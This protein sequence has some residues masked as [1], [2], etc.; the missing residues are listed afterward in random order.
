MKVRA[1]ARAAARR[2]PLE[3]EE[4][5]AEEEEKAKDGEEG[6]AVEAIGADKVKLS[7][8]DTYVSGG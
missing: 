3:D 8:V 5:E 4:R 1:R 6:V 7:Y 2:L